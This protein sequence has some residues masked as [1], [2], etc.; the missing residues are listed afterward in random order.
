M[1]LDDPRCFT[2]EMT[3]ARRAE[4]KSLLKLGALKIIIREDLI[5]HGNILPGRFVL[6]IK[7]T[8]DGEIKYRARYFIGGRRGRFKH[9]MAH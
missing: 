1:D 7:C 3:D 4:V 6:A 2:R 8:E 5:P 9:M